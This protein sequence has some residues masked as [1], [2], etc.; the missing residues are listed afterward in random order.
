MP[1]RLRAQ[2]EEVRQAARRPWPLPHPPE[3][4][5]AMGVTGNGD[6]LFWATQPSGVPDEWTIAVNE[7]LCAPWFTYNGTVTEFLVDVLSANVR[8]PMFHSDLLDGGVTFTPSQ[9]RSTATA[10]AS[11]TSVSTHVIREWARANGYDLPERGRIPIEIIQAWEQ[12]NP[13]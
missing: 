5:L 9:L 13:R 7:A 11:R 8:V 3:D 1:E 10:T 12:A 6:Y 4:L 2:I